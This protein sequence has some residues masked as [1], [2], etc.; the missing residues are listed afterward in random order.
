[1]VSELQEQGMYHIWNG[2]HNIVVIKNYVTSCEMVLSVPMLNHKYPWSN[3]SL[4][5]SLIGIYTLSLTH[6]HTHTP[7]SQ[8]N[9]VKP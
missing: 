3:G 4:P 2:T 7:S 8:K 9:K 1:M 6:T 5:L